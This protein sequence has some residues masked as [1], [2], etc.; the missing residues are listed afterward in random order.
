[1]PTTRQEICKCGT[2]VAEFLNDISIFEDN[3]KRVKEEESATFIPAF[4]SS[5]N[6][7]YS[8]IG[9]IEDDCGIDTHGI[10]WSNSD[11]FNK[12][13]KIEAIKDS[14]KFNEKKSDILSDL[15]RIRYGIVQK[16]KDCSK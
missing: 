2:N 1:M 3:L 5:V 16:I 14:T 9:K 4:K 8:N 15:S 12:I 11:I 13:E 6:S 10:R 7:I